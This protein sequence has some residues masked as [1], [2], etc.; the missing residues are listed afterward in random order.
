MRL[1]VRARAA[2]VPGDRPAVLWIKGGV[3]YVAV[4]DVY[5]WKRR[6][7]FRQ[8]IFELHPDRAG[9]V[10]RSQW[11]S[12]QREYDTW[13]REE[14]RWYSA[15]G[16]DV[17]RGEQRPVENVFEATYRAVLMEG[18]RLAGQHGPT[19]ADILGVSLSAFYGAVHRHG[20]PK[21]TVHG[22]SRRPLIGV[23]QGSVVSCVDAIAKAMPAPFRRRD[24]ARR[25]V[26]ELAREGRAVLFDTALSA[27]RDREKAGTLIRVGKA[28]KANGRA[29]KRPIFV[30][31]DH[32]TK[33]YL[34][35]GTHD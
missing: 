7:A 1:K 15:L 20:I 2:L 23:R 34:R 26:Q 18:I 16:L 32:F 8:R 10:N 30:H 11:A 5:Y 4:H 27:V 29:G 19:A 33:R 25:V 13:L 9:S 12:L 22:Q 35:S 6:K 21:G 17:P 14:K 28:L 3:V 31:R 24:L